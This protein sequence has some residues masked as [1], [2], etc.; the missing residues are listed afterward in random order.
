MP[1]GRSDAQAVSQNASHTKARRPALF[2]LYLKFMTESAPLRGA[3]E[4]GKPPRAT[5]GLSFGQRQVS[6]ERGSCE[7]LVDSTEHL[8]SVPMPL[9][10]V[11]IQA[12]VTKEFY[13]LVLKAKKSKI[14]VSALASF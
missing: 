6:E 3:G 9:P 1:P 14:K 10:L 5:L 2:V 7:F 8:N 11:I 4:S 13:F 12:A